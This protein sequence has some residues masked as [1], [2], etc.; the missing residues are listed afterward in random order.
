MPSCQVSRLFNFGWLEDDADVDVDPIENFRLPKAEAN[1]CAPPSAC[2]RLS[3]DDDGPIEYIESCDITD[4]EK[5]VIDHK[6]LP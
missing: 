6:P 2:P 1:A 3:V 4:T 5:N